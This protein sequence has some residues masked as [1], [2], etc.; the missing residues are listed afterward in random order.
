MMVFGKSYD[1]NLGSP[2]YRMTRIWKY[3]PN[4]AKSYDE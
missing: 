4:I 2:K 1:F 3:S